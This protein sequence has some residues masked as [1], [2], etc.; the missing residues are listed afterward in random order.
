MKVLRGLQNMTLGIEERH[1]AVSEIRLGRSSVFGLLKPFGFFDLPETRPDRTTIR[2]GIRSV[3]V[4]FR[5]SQQKN[6]YV[7]LPF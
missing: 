1:I 7:S 5:N 2:F 6:F 4:G 3:S